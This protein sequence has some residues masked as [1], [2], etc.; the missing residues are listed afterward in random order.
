MRANSSLLISK[1]CQQGCFGN[2]MP[3]LEYIVYIVGA[4]GRGSVVT[5]HALR[6]EEPRRLSVKA[7]WHISSTPPRSLM[8]DR[9][10]SKIGM[11][12]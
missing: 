5:A 9:Q 1:Q 10:H 6:S 3:T 8:G 11:E 4:R 2:R 7:S 12:A